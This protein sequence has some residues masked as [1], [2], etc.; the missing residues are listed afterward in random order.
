MFSFQINTIRAIVWLGVVAGLFLDAPAHALIAG[1]AKVEITPSSGVPLNGYGNRQGRGAVETH[2]PL[3]ARALYLEDADTRVF[4]VTADLCVINRELRERVLALAPALVPPENIILTATHTHNG[5]G[6]MMKPLVAR[7]I[8]GRFMPDVLKETAERFAD[9]MQEAYNAK[10]RATVAFGTAN[11]QVLSVNRRDPGGLFDSQIGV[12]RVD[13]SDGNPIAILSNF[14]AHPTTIGEEYS[15]AFSADYPGYYYEALEALTAP[16]CVAMFLNG[17]EGNQAC[18]N[19]EDNAGWDRTESIGRLLAIRTKEVSNRLVGES[20]SIYVASSTPQLPATLANSFL[21]GETFLQTLEIGDLLLTFFPGE[22]VVEIGIEM[23]RQALA[24]GYAAQFTVG[25]AN[26][27]LGYFVTRDLYGSGSYESNMS[28][29]GP[30]MEDWFYREFTALQTRA[31]APPETAAAIPAETQPFAGGTRVDLSG[32]FEEMGRRRA[33]AFEDQIRTAYEERVFLPVDDGALTPD[34][35]LFS[36]APSF[37]DKTPLALPSLGIS[38]RPL[39][40]GLGPSLIGEIA[41]MAHALNMPFDALWML[42]NAPTYLVPDYR[43][44]LFAAPFCTMVAATGDRAGADD[45]LVAQNFDW[46]LEEEPVVFVVRPPEGRSYIHVGFPWNA[47]VFTGM[48]DAGIVLCVESSGGEPRSD[49]SVPPI[50]FVLREALLTAGTFEEAVQAIR[51]H[52]SLSGYHVLVADP[53]GA[54]AAVL[55]LGGEIRI[56]EPKEGL[57]FG[58]LPDTPGLDSSIATRYRRARDLSLD[59][60][61]LAVSELQSLLGDREPGQSAQSRI[62]NESTRN[63]VVFEPGARRMHIAFPKP[64]GGLGAFETIS[65]RGAAR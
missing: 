64:D 10:E 11:Q 60:R 33:L 2:D 27:H 43:D 28:F 42:Q 38:T 49:R 50:E 6:G 21:P 32:S 51:K 45:L 9:V 35:G 39:L 47:G 41:G 30:T 5:H 61:I 29:Y 46:P 22:P 62:F 40:A 52:K 3:W 4:L 1:A 44:A 7:A 25:L 58:S 13:D 48:N 16:G 34:S 19:P 14:A 26:D 36:L 18:G 23:R 12:I 17:A 53:K 65:L 24:R 15:L 57:L 56:R 20:L 54:R 59:E 55:E 37:I 63:A 8:S 31:P